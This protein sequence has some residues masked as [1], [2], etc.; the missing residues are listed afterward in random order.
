M[1]SNE[2]LLLCG[3]FYAGKPNENIRKYKF[4]RIA[5]KESETEKDEASGI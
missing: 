5:V 4:T 1:K 2:D 3:A